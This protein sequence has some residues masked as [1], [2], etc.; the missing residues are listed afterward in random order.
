MKV[1]ELKESISEV[2]F[3]I[4][5]ELFKEKGELD[6]IEVIGE[7]NIEELGRND[8]MSFL[9]EFYLVE[10]KEKFEFELVVSEEKDNVF[11]VEEKVEKVVEEQLNVLEEKLDFEEVKIE[12]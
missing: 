9:K 5:I 12:D 10:E 2:D 8:E 7:I 6:N 11:N 3:C 4:D 1:D